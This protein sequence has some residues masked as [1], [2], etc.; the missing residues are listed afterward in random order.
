[1]DKKE[2]Y[3]EA[4]DWRVTVYFDADIRNYR[5]ITGHLIDLGITPERLSRACGLLLSDRYNYGLTHSNLNA[6]ETVIAI[7]PTTSRAEFFNSIEHELRHLTD[8]IALAFDLDPAGEEVGYLTG[9]IN[10]YLT[11]K[12]QERICSCGKPNH[13]GPCR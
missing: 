11:G 1:M 9:D 4:Y 7:G 2:L 5:D 13:E 3:L 6:R 10:Y 8:D 12:I